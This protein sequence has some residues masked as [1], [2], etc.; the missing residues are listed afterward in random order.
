MIGH[1]IRF[2]PDHRRRRISSRAGQIGDVAM[3]AHSMTTSLPG[4]S[5]GG[6]LAR[7][8]ESGGPLLDLSV[9][10]FDYRPG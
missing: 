6:W 4:W 3:M 7:P 2:E 5:E 9:H 10:S 1:V 8:E